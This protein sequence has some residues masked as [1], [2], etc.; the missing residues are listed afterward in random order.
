[1]SPFPRHPLVGEKTG[2]RSIDLFHLPFSTS[3][4]HR[5]TVRMS[6]AY[7]L[8][9]PPPDPSAA[10]PSRRRSVGLFH[11]PFL[12]FI[13]ASSNSQNIGSMQCISSLSPFATHQLFLPLDILEAEQTEAQ[14]LNYFGADFVFVVNSWIRISEIAFRVNSC[15]Q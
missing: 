6:S 12:H 7:F 9:L 4:R 11:F 2:W 10:S 14:Q 15:W 1:M 8:P 5:A 13:K 3:L